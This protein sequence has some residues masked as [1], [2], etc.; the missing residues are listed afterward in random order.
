M[1]AKI[2]LFFIVAAMLVASCGGERH[3]YKG[4]LTTTLEMSGS[5]DVVGSDNDEVDVTVTKSGDNKMSLNF[6]TAGDSKIKT[7]LEGCTVEMTK[8]YGESWN[9]NGS[10]ECNAEG[11]KMQILKGNATMDAKKLD[12]SLEAVVY[13]SGKSNK[14]QFSGIEAK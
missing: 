9:E 4:T 2:Q 14:Y 8:L 6:K 5:G 3:I 13:G 7:E 1:N 10:K 11:R 12:L